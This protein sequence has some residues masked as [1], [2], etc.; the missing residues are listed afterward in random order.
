MMGRL[1]AISFLTLAGSVFPTAQAGSPQLAKA[2][3]A[4]G[5]FWSME[6]P[7]D[8]LEGVI[9]TTV[10]YTGGVKKNPTYE[11]VSLGRTGHLESVQ[12][13][14]D[15]GKVSYEELLD[16]FWHNVDPLDGV[17]QFCDQGSQYR[18]A[19]FYHDE[20]QRLAAQQSKRAL[21]QSGRFQ[22]VLATQVLAAKEFYRAEE[23]HQDFYKK[24]PSQYTSYRDNCG[25]AERLADL[26]GP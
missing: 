22:T 17:G 5:C 7:F 3:F 23:Y 20:A 16:V 9:S 26:W 13:E 10:G 25:R 14:Y 11:E 8:K 2:T 12:V 19:I 21:V 6:P 18:T 15:P 1:F 24:N 4:G